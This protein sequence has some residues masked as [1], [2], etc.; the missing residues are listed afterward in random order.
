M[1]RP[2]AAALLMLGLAASTDCVAQ[3]GSV[4]PPADASTDSTRQAN[5]VE[6]ARL[7]NEHRARVRCR[8]LA[9]DA[10]AV[11]AAQAH[12][13]DMARRD[14][15]DD[16]SPE[17]HDVRDRLRAAGAHPLLAGENLASGPL[18]ASEVVRAWLDSP[19]QRAL[20]ETCGYTHQGVGY[21]DEVWTLVL[22]VPR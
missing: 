5:V 16:V 19:A 10:A 15:F 13:D 8:P 12:S 3:A 2:L 21:R 14:Y 17:G 20:I 22:F 11:R 18:E 9:W 6:A 7:V 1:S 4:A